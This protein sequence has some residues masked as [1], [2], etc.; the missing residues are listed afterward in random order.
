[1]SPK[2]RRS[3]EDLSKILSSAADSIVEDGLGRLRYR[4]IAE[5]AGVSIGTLQHYFGSL[6]NLLLETLRYVDRAIDWG[7]PDTEEEDSWLAILRSLDHLIDATGSTLP[8]VWSR[9]WEADNTHTRLREEAAQLYRG[10]ANLFEETVARGTRSGRFAP[11]LAPDVLSE[12][13]MSLIDGTTLGVSGGRMER[14]AARRSLH[15]VV[16]VLLGVRGVSEASPPP[17]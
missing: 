9:I 7:A 17:P 10:W 16:A 12:T 2:P 8:I 14:E 3:N 5:R 11:E 13:I 15:Q 4:N 6:E 1:M